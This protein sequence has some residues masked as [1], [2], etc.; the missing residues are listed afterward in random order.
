[1]AEAK[2]PYRILQRYEIPIGGRPY[3]F[4][5]A[6]SADGVVSWLPDNEQQHLNPQYRGP[7]GV[8]PVTVDKMSPKDIQRMLA[9]VI[10]FQT[11]EQTPLEGIAKQ[12]RKLTR[13][14][15]LD[16]KNTSAYQAV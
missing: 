8:N 3:G 12:H 6:L 14:I 13:T 16:F 11:K 5:S 7:V 4:Y 15:E 2:G 1:M 9:Q 10:L